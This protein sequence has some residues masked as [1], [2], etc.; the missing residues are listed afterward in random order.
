MYSKN[1]LNV[2]TPEGIDFKNAFFKTRFFCSNP[3]IKKEKYFIE[4]YLHK[5]F[6]QIYWYQS[7]KMPQ[8]SIFLNKNTPFKFMLK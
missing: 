4:P 2:S 5:L 7:S 6:N 8:L 1:S 3:P